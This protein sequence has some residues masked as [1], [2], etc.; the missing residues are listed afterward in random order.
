M[1]FATSISCEIQSQKIKDLISDNRYGHRAFFLLCALRDII[2]NRSNTGVVAP[3]ELKVS[4]CLRLLPLR[5][6]REEFYRICSRLKELN[7]I[8]FSNSGESIRFSV[9]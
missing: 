2:V 9:Y 6:S 1:F 4:D 7:K 8:D 5:Y 3:L